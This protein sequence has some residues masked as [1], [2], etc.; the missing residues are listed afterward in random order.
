M[1]GGGEAVIEWEEKQRQESVL[2]DNLKL[3]KL[4][5]EEHNDAIRR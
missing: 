4:K 5:C 1:D 2:E 3:M